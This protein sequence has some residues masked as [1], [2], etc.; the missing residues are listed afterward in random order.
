MTVF[1]SITAT[2]NKGVCLERPPVTALPMDTLPIR[3]C[4]AGL[5]YRILQFSSYLSVA[6]DYYS[7]AADISPLTSR[8]LVT[9][10]CGST[11]WQ[12]SGYRQGRSRAL[13]SALRSR[14]IVPREMARPGISLASSEDRQALRFGCDRAF[15]GST[16]GASGRTAATFCM[17]HPWHEVPGGYSVIQERLTDF[18]TT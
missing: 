11:V 17:S 15:A 16:A 10:S 5:H 3:G 2:G 14:K 1:G 18:S 4:V 8:L 6:A 7:D 13:L 9:Y 12:E